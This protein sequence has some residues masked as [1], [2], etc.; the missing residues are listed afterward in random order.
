MQ[1]QGEFSEIDFQEQIKQFSQRKWNSLSARQRALASKVWRVLTFKWRWQI[2]M[3]VP[4]LG[5]FLLD[6]T[7]PAVHK[8][9]VALLATI[10]S[11]LPIPAFLSSWMGLG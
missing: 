7:V 3:N 8:F 5:F 9:D 2:A 6:R 11:K 1:S 4:Y 10:A